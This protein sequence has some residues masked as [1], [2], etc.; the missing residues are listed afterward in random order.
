MKARSVSRCCSGGTIWELA[1]LVAGLTCTDAS[2]DLVFSGNAFTV[3]ASNDDGTGLLEVSVADLT[4]N[5]QLNRWTWSLPAPV[6]ITNGSGDVI[7]QVTSANVIYRGDPQIAFGFSAIAGGSTT[8]FV[9]ASSL[10]SFPVIPSALANASAGLTLTDGDGNGGTLQGLHA[11]GGA[12]LAEYNGGTDF[13]ELV[14]PLNAPACGSVSDSDIVPLTALG[15][16]VSS[17]NAW[18]YFSLTANDLASGTSNYQITPEPGA[19]GFLLVTLLL[20]R[21]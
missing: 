8:T 18:Y 14:G 17:M 10:I 21:R 7:A 6:D 12:Y 3:E 20:R 15:T 11:A 9:I 19:I 13:A 1:V 4:Y 5:P 16:S 2:A